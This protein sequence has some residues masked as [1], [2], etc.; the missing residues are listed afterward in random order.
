M[1]EHWTQWSLS[2]RKIHL[3]LCLRLPAVERTTD[4]GIP[5]WLKEKDRKRKALEE[6]KRH[7]EEFPR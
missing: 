5:D 4:D 1:F 3:E 2:Y 7:Y 6:L